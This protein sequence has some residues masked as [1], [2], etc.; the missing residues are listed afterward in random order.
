MPACAAIPLF[1]HSGESTP[2][3]GG[4]C[5]RRNQSAGA[6]NTGACSS[7]AEI[8]RGA[9]EQSR[10]APDVRQAQKRGAGDGRQSAPPKHKNAHNRGRFAGPRPSVGDTGLEPV[11]SALSIRARVPTTSSYV[12]KPQCLPGFQAACCASV[13]GSSSLFVGRMWEELWETER[14]LRAASCARLGS[15]WL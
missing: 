8:I 10:C 3:L 13:P 1:D 4:Q 5:A 12:A 9:R 2:A 11:T 7:A 14:I 15:R 6:G